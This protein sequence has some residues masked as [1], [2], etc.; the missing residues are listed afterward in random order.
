MSRNASRRGGNSLTTLLGM[1]TSINSS[2]QCN[3]M[4]PVGDKPFM[5]VPRNVVSQRK[6]ANDS[7]RSFRTAHDAYATTVV[8][9]RFGY[10]KVL[11]VCGTVNSLMSFPALL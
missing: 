7:L 1:L 2:S 4:V 3:D 9:C 5:S 6:S 8:L 10:E 11:S